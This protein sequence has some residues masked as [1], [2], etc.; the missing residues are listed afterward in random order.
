MQKGS[1]GL[2][3]AYVESHKAYVELHEAHVEL[4]K[5]YVEAHKAYVEV[6]GAHV[7]VHRALATH[8][9]PRDPSHGK[10]QRLCFYKYI[11]LVLLDLLSVAVLI[12]TVDEDGSL[13][14]LAVS[15]DK[16]CTQQTEVH[17]A[18]IEVC[19]ACVELHTA[20]VERLEGSGTHPGCS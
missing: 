15:L 14:L 2:H 10:V 19:K 8:R 1:V 5:A 16:L 7:E 17:K 12:H 20:Y 6:H 3:K 4:H 11:V 13:V 9:N 18:D